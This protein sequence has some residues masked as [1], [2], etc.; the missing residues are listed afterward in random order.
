MAVPFL[1]LQMPISAG[2]GKPQNKAMK[3]HRKQRQYIYRHCQLCRVTPSYAVFVG[4]CIVILPMLELATERVQLT[5]M[6][7]RN[8]INLAH[9]HHMTFSH[10]HLL[11]FLSNVL[12]AIVLQNTVAWSNI[13]CQSSHSRVRHVSLSPTPTVPTGLGRRVVGVVLLLLLLIS[14]DIETN[15]GPI[16]ECTSLMY[17]F[18]M[19]AYFIQL[20]NWMSVTQLKIGLHNW[21]PWCITC[22]AKLPG[23]ATRVFE[24][25]VFVRMNGLNAAQ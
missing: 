24:S 21:L 15:P 8:P 25:Y 20:H 3:A 10:T 7:C 17:T 11:P 19:D 16:G 22:E 23:C 1:S 2:H 5:T 18:R 6:Y 4:V 14:G 13:K 12:P 9:P